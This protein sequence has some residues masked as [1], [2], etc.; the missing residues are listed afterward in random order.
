MLMNVGKVRDGKGKAKKRE[1][2]YL[3]LFNDLLIV[4][5]KKKWVLDCRPEKFQIK[6][7]NLF[8]RLIENLIPLWW[9][10]L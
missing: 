4:A 3:Y 1:N 7:Y 10:T 5:K 2:K 8:Y 6:H 9:F